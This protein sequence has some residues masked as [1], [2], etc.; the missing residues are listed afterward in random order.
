MAFV[1]CGGLG[2]GA[3]KQMLVYY[4]DEMVLGSISGAFLADV[5]GDV[6]KAAV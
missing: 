2:G 6:R 1:R 5:D 3:G 4:G